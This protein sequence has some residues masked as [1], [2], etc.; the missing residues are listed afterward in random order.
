[1]ERKKRTLFAVLIAAIIVMAVF[2]SYAMN[3]FGRESY[4]VALPDLSE[5]TDP[6]QDGDGGQDAGRFVRVEVTPETVQAVVQTLKR[7]QSYY[8]QISIELW[9][10]QES[11]TTT[12]QVW[13]DGGWTRSEVTGPGGRV[14][15]NLVKEQERWLWYDGDSEAVSLPA[16][17]LASDLVQ[18]TPTYEDVLALSPE[19]ITDTGYEPYA[20]EDCIYIEVE[21]PELGSRERYWIAVSNGL[22]MGAQRVRGEQLLYRMQALYTESPAPLSSVFALPDG[23]V[24]HTVGAQEGEV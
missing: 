3:L 4:H 24:M 14:Q 20:Q 1:M 23:T 10:G 17:P 11:S 15:H 9:A 5:G 7:P 18:R 8:R 19:D 12:V 2:S 16:S 6:D 22:L 21:Q 13:T